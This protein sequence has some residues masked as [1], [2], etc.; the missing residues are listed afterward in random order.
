MGN[1]N[2]GY[3]EHCNSYSSRG[4]N[5]VMGVGVLRGSTLRGCLKAISSSGLNNPQ[6]FSGPLFN[7][8]FARKF[9]KWES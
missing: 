3:N 2:T 9:A 7:V 4:R 6:L 8:K 5:S 1:F